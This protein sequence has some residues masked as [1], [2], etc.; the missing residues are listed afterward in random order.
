MICFRQHESFCLEKCLDNMDGIPIES[1]VATSMTDL[2]EETAIPF[3]IRRSE[4]RS[5]CKV[6]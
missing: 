6:V 5:I 4:N 3:G 2:I 1:A